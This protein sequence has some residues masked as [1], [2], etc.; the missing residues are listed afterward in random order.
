[1]VEEHDS[2]NGIM[3]AVE[4]G[5]GVTI[6]IDVLGHNFGPSKLVHITPDQTDLVGH[7]RAKRK[8]QPSREKFWPVRQRSGV[9]QIESVDGRSTKTARAEIVAESIVSSFS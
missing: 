4:A 2:Y 1:V 3:S 6:A 7:R 5:T 9:K 8:T